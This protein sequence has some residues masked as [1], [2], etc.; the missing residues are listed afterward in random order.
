[1]LCIFCRGTGVEG[2][3]HADI[4][5][6]AFGYIFVILMDGFGQFRSWNGASAGGGSLKWVGR[7]PETRCP[8]L[9]FRGFPH[10]HKANFGTFCFVWA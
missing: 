9:T 3:C 4:N 10:F 6:L 2:I 8:D 7:L 5:C 1:M